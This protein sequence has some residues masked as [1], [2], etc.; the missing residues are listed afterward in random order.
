MRVKSQTSKITGEKGNV[1]MDITVIQSHQ[2]LVQT[3][4][5]Q[6]DGK[7]RKNV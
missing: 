4:V 6:Q 1:R 5:C 2:E 7:C 3:T